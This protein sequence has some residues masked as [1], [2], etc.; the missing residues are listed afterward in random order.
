MFCGAD[1]E[2][3]LNLISEAGGASCLLQDTAHLAASVA[4]PLIQRQLQ[5]RTYVVLISYI[6]T[7]N[8]QFSVC[9]C[10]FR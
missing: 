5:V 4:L 3:L 6:R 9:S 8:T 7:A 1:S 2:D 10:Y